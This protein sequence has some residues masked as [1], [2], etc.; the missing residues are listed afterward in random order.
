MEAPSVRAS[1]VDAQKAPKAFWCCEDFRPVVGDR[2]E[3]LAAR[4]LSL[5]PRR[6][7]GIVDQ[8]N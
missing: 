8:R 6:E 3:F 4:Q 1:G 2:K 5:V 7:K